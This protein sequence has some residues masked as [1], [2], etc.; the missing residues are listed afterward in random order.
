MDAASWN[1]TPEP[2]QWIPHQYQERVISLFLRQGAGGALLDPGLGKTSISLAVAKILRQKGLIKRW[3]LIA[4][5][6]P[7][8]HTWPAEIEKWADFNDLNMHILHGK[9]RVVASIPE[10]TDIVGINPEGLP[11]LMHKD[12]PYRMKELSCNGLIVDESTRFKHSNTK[13]FKLL[14]PHI[15]SFKRR[16]I[17]TGSICPNGLMDLFGQIYILDQGN[18]LGPYITKFRQE[19]FSQV[20]PFDPY[21]WSPQEGSFDRIV[22]RISPLVIQLQAEDYLKMPEMVKIDI[23]VQLDEQTMETY[24]SLE[25]EFVTLVNENPLIAQNA[26]VA[27]MKCRQMANGAVYVGDKE[28]RT[29]AIVHDGKLEALESLIEELSGAPTLVVYEFQHDKERIMKQ[30]KQARAFSGKEKEDRT[31]INQFNNGAV[32][33]LVGHPQSMG[34]GLNL[35]GACHHV[36]F[37]GITWNFEFYDQVI[38]RVYRQGQES[39]HV[40]VYHIMSMGTVD[41]RVTRVLKGKERTQRA[42]LNA[43]IDTV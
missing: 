38:R 40:F 1:V 16:Y 10:D 33:M 2:T 12:F 43:L 26:A 27:G 20:N 41:E 30:H 17:L 3:L 29:T 11:W 9:G 24:K 14:R 35:Q 36:I 32:E 8:Y 37:Y 25:D 19:Y 34:H 39:D 5:L 15:N 28:D 4:P 22:D 6:R 7:L 13:R 18:S 31:L 23:P 21:T 42:L